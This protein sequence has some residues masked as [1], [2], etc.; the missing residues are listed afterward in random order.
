MV[1]SGVD[2]T[3]VQDSSS[4]RDEE[5]V[6]HLNTVLADTNIIPVW[7]VRDHDSEPQASTSATG[8]STPQTSTA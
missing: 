7:D 5:F 6:R 1:Y 2:L 3:V 8:A 4:R